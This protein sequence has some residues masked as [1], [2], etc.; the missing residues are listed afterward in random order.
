MIQIVSD[1]SAQ[2]QQFFPSPRYNTAFAAVRR[3][4]VIIPLSVLI[5]IH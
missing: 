3:L 2:Q 4:A 1:F 5:A